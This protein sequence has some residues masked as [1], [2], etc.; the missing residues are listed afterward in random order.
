MTSYI[1]HSPD[2]VD[3]ATVEWYESLTVPGVRYAVRK[4]TLGQRI[5]L[6]KRA[7][8]LAGKHEYLRTGDAA[9][10]LEATTHQQLQRLRPGL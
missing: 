6:T 1:S 4:I 3:F 9:D 10:Q 2:R 5:E 8:E 7:R